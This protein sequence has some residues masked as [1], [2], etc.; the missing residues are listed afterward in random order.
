MSSLLACLPLSELEALS[1]KG[2]E[3]TDSP[4]TVF[5][6]AFG[7]LMPWEGENEMDW[8]PV[9]REELAGSGKGWHYPDL[10]SH[11]KLLTVGEGRGERREERK[12]EREYECKK[13]GALTGRVC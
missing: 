6:A 11:M 3:R 5:L 10:L 1:P 8:C 12:R 7:P 2:L 4:R 13:L 9:C